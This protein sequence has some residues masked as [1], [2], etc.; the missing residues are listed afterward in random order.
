MHAARGGTVV[1][2]AYRSFSGGTDAADAD[3]A[4][5]V[6]ILHDDGTLAI[7]AHLSLNSVRVRP[8][9][10]VVAGQY[11]ANSGNTGFSSG[12]HLHFAVERNIGMSL[13][14]VPVRFVGERGRPATAQ[15]GLPLRAY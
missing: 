11:I 5:L 10:E 1:A 12:P 13:K 8:G 2:I 9:D 14:T 6:Q 15:T 4:N 7:Y 3:K